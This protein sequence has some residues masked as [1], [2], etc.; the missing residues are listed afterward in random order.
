M[1]DSIQDLSLQG[2]SAR[3]TRGV[4]YSWKE[5]AAYMCRGVRTLQRYEKQ[6]GFPVHRLAGRKTGS[7][8]AF[9]DEIETWIRCT[10]LN[11]SPETETSGSAS[12]DKLREAKAALQQAYTAYQEAL[13]R[14]NDLI[15]RAG[16]TSNVKTPE[17]A[18]EKAK[19]ASAA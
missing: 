12:E 6:L 7:I 3:N 4:L 13:H 5:I 14:Y 19:G 11:L 17:V 8:V 16:H 18:T 1:G 9:V 15:N 10:P 2:S